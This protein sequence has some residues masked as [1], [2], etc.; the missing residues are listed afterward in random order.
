[1]SLEDGDELDALQ[2]DVA[3]V[4]EAMLALPLILPGTRFRRGIEARKRIMITLGK[5]INDRRRTKTRK[6]DFLEHLLNMK[7]TL[8]DEEIKDNVLTMIIAGNPN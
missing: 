1:M 7:E 4:C 6:D 5:I 3:F 8:I 2:N